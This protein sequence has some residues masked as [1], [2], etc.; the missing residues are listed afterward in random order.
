MLAIVVDSEDALAFA[1]MRGDEAS[2]VAEILG[3]KFGK[4]TFLG[5]HGDCEYSKFQFRAMRKISCTDFTKNNSG[6]FAR[7]IWTIFD[8]YLIKAL[9]HFHC[10]HQDRKH[11]IT[12]R[13]GNR[14]LD[15]ILPLCAGQNIHEFKIIRNEGLSVS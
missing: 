6:F 4:G 1:V 7:F 14:E 13:C 9:S 11:R 15:V 12:R 5:R 2:W 3:W 10:S 8:L